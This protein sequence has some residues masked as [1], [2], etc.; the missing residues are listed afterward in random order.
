M[1]YFQA[2]LNS[3]VSSGQLFLEGGGTL[4][5]AEVCVEWDSTE[6]FVYRCHLADQQQQ[7]EKKDYQLVCKESL[8][9]IRCN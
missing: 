5:S 1:K 4:E 9:D 7:Q 2:P 6:D 8:Q 3:R